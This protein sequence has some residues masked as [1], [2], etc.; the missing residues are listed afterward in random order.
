MRIEGDIHLGAIARAFRWPIAGTWAIV[1]VENVLLALIPLLI[2]FAIDGLL[3][4]G[5]RELGL[6]GGV[7]VLL[8]V[9]AVLRRFYDT[10]VYSRIRVE[11]GTRVDRKQATLDVSAKDARLDMARE[12]VDFLEIEAPGLLTAIVQMVVTLVVLSIFHVHL[13]FSAGAVTLAMVVVYSCFHNRFYRL[14]AELNAQKE[15][16][17]R[18]VGERRRLSLLRHLRALQRSEIRISDTEAIVYGMIFLSQIAFIIC[19][20]WLA[21]RLEDM[22]TGKIFAIVTYSWEYIEA[23]LMLP[24]AMQSWS[25]LSEISSRINSAN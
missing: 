19:N 12:L 16:Q 3:A 17:V 6:L 2:G 11:L 13:A 14:N 23:A 1:L 25:R 15:Q 20:L 8:T 5:L 9:I 24:I 21:S 4:G 22:S 10:R 7:L 18:I